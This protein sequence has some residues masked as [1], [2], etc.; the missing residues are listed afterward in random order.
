MAR[1]YLTRTVALH[2]D[3]ESRAHSE[4]AKIR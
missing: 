4:L 2:G 3:F 1:H